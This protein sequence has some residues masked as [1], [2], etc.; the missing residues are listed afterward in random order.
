MWTTVGYSSG[1]MIAEKA[2]FTI[3][4]TAT[5]RA[6]GLRVYFLLSLDSI[7]KG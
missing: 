5:S 2:G 6:T 4:E 1:R 3:P 7:R